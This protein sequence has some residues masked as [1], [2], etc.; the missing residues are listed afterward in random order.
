MSI[1]SASQVAREGASRSPE[2]D[3]EIASC[4]CRCFP[5]VSA[6]R[7]PGST[8]LPDL[9]RHSG[10]SGVS[11]KVERGAYFLG[12]G[13]LSSEG[14]KANSS[15]TTATEPGDRDEAFFENVNDFG[16]RPKLEVVTHVELASEADGALSF[17]LSAF[18]C[19]TGVFLV[20]IKELL[21]SRFE[22]LIH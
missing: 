15:E 18:E 17:T 11:T 6:S 3:F 16:E 1:D 9:L 21:G 12:I 4:T 19:L 22:A 8:F 10:P 2:V 5:P 13:K 14:S 7:P 20:E